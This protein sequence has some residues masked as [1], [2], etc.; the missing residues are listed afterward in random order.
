MKNLYSLN[1]EEIIEMCKE[2]LFDKKDTKIL[3]HI[4]VDELCIKQMD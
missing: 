3:L 2:L 4:I 1:S